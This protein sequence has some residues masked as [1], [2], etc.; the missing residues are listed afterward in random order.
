MPKTA[1]NWAQ[2]GEN[3]CMVDWRDLS[4]SYNYP[5][6]AI[7][8]TIRVKIAITRFLQYLKICHYMNIAN[9]SIAGHSLGAHV[10]IMFYYI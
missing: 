6:V 3:V 8:N 4:S 9:V 2:N 5:V 1:A 7:Q 10:G